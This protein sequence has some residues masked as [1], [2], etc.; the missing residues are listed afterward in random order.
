M[1]SLSNYNINQM[2][3]INN[4][5]NTKLINTEPRNT[6]RQFQS[7]KEYISDGIN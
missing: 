1:K 7:E 2:E 6:F 5:P 4:S 3:S